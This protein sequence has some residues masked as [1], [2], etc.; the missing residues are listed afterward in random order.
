MDVIL[1]LVAVS[2]AGLYIQNLDAN[3]Q[4][5]RSFTDWC[6]TSGGYGI[7]CFLVACYTVVLAVV[8]VLW[9]FGGV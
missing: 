8:L 3:N 9:P 2:I 5:V 4:I 1:T 6:R 7:M